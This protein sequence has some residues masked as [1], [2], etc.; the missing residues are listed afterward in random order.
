MGCVI[1]EEGYLKG[2]R[3]L[4]TKHNIIL[5][6]DEV[7]TGF[8]L[9][10]GGAQERFG[11]TPDMTTMGKILGGG[12]PVG[13]YGGRRDIMD[14]MSPVGPV[15]QAGT[16]SGNP[17]AMAAGLAMLRYLKANPSVYKQL[18]ESTTKL[19][20]GIRSQLSEAGLPYT[21]NQV[22]SMFTLFFTDVKVI[23]FD[24]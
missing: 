5:I 11:V 18:D 21:V 13:A 23:D 19:A 1:P 7:M 15:Y 17:L 2:L 8:R 20:D 14:S 9:S 22:G 6:F 4:C 24:T 12:L 10:L 3:D 16:L